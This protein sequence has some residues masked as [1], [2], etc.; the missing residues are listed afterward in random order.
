M[1]VDRRFLKVAMSKQ[2]LD[3]AQVSAGFQQVCG[4]AVAKGILVLLMICI[5]QRSVIHVIPSTGLRWKLFDIC[6]GRSRRF[7]SSDFRQEHRSH[8]RS[9]C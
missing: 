3:G 1:Q 4:K 9:G 6:E 7:S 5:P 2:H 8:Y